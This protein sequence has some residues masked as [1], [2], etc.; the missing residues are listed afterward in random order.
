MGSGGVPS[1]GVAIF[2]DRR[3]SSTGKPMSRSDRYKNGKKVQSRWYDAFGRAIRD[4]DYSHQNGDKS[5]EFPHDHFWKWENG[6]GVRGKVAL[7][8]DDVHYV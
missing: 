5:H 2:N 3:L 6:I 1:G 7:P 8:P 4:R